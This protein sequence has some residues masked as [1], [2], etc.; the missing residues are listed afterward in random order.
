MMKK[1]LTHASAEISNLT[2]HL[3]PFVGTHA[4]SCLICGESKKSN[5]RKSPFDTLSQ[6][7]VVQTSSDLDLLKSNKFRSVFLH[8]EFLQQ[9]TH[10]E[11]THCLQHLRMHLMYR[12]FTQKEFSL[13]YQE[14]SLDEVRLLLIPDT[15]SLSTL[16]FVNKVTKYIFILPNAL[17]SF[18]DQGSIRYIAI[19]YIEFET[20]FRVILHYL[21]QRKYRLQL[22]ELSAVL[23]E[24]KCGFVKYHPLF[25]LDT[26][27]FL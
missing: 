17:E 24:H 21:M 16:K 22:K 3:N 9:Q 2:M 20:F 5:D 15:F 11:V 25:N 18:F 7:I 13:C 1:V 12:I 14:D 10:G 27:I 19:F 6:L 26:C 23:Q 8:P 4:S